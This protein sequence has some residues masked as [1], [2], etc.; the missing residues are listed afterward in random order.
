MASHHARPD[1]INCA[2]LDVLQEQVDGTP[3]MIEGSVVV[4]S[5]QPALVAL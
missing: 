5:G 1:V 2:I 3:E 4:S